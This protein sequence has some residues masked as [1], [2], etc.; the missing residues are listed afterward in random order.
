MRLLLLGTG[1][2]ARLHVKGFREVEGVE[3]VGAVDTDPNRL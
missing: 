2:M 1:G 3:L